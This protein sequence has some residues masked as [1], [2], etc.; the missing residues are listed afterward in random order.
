MAVNL[1]IDMI[2]E[3]LQAIES[4]LTEYEHKYKLL[5]LHFYK[6]YQAGKLEEHSDFVD[7]AALNC[8]KLKRIKLYKFMIPP[9]IVDS[10]PLNNPVR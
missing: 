6:I 5:S 3:D 8:I 7:G 9:V 10:L 2:L 1:T 4:K